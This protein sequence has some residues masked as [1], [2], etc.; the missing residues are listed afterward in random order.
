MVTTARKG[1]VS[2]RSF[3]KKGKE[4]THISSLLGVKRHKRV[5]DIFWNFSATHRL[6]STKIPYG[7]HTFEK[8]S[9]LNMN[10]GTPSVQK[11]L[12]FRVYSVAAHTWLLLYHQM[13]WRT[14][15]TVAGHRLHRSGLSLVPGIYKAA[16]FFFFHASQPKSSCW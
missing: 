3:D 10:R 5:A 1:S 12:P 15:N 6:T 11:I 9:G 8:Q 4:K 14:R 2:S 13:T 16:T 7:L